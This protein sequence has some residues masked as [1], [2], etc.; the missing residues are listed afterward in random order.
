MSN[1]SGTVNN[2]TDAESEEY[3]PGAK[4]RRYK[5]SNSRVRESSGR[6]I[7][8]IQR[9][10]FVVIAAALGF[11]LLELPWNE[12]LFTME[13]HYV[14]P[15]LLI[16]F[17]CCVICYFLGQRTRVSLAVFVGLC[18]LGGYANF[19][20]IAFKGQPIVPADLFALNT[21][22]AVS[23]G[24]TFFITPSLIMCLALFVLFCLAL[25]FLCPKSALSKS[26][27]A[28][29][30]LAA[31]LLIC[32]GG[33]QYD[34]IDVKQDCEV[35]VDV[36]DVRGSY[37]T[38]GSALCFVSRMQ[39]LT[40]KQPQGYSPLAVQ[41]LVEPY[42]DQSTWGDTQ[43]HQDVDFQAASNFSDPSNDF[44]RPNI[45]V[46]MNETF[47]D[48]SRYPGLEDAQR[49]TEGY[50]HLAESSLASGNVYVSALGGGT[51]NS[52]FEFLTA[53]TMGLMGGGVYPYVLY[54]LEEVDNVVAYFNDLGYATSAIHPA[55]AANWRRDRIYAQLG[56]NRFDDI[57]AFEN[58]E[59][60]RDLTTDKA[61]YEHLLTILQDCDDPQ[62]IFDVT[63]QNHGGYDTGLVP[64]ED[65]VHLESSVIDNPEVDEFLA[66][67]ERS[68]KDL[69]WLTDA[70]NAYRE[71]T[72]VV[73]FGDH[74]PG[75]ADELFEAAYGKPVDGS[76]L[77]EVQQRYQTPYLIWANDATYEVYGDRIQ[78]LPPA[79]DMS[80]NY[81][82]SLL[83]TVLDLPQ[84]ARSRY[85]M[86]IHN[87]L[88]AVNL[89][90]YC[91]SDGLWHW[92][93]EAIESDA[94]KR[95]EA[96]LES[97]ELVQYDN[98]FA[99]DPVLHEL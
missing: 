39:E 51:C 68:D 15:N 52:E 5:G 93:G 29:N 32:L 84:T 2:S 23:G 53:S 67:I 3:V 70:L 41:A 96:A 78:A 11:L 90:G 82:S 38:Q 13:W 55:E 36:W 4:L 43:A 61:T 31:L 37:A 44:V 17:L 27:I 54:D 85:L 79:Q 87:D 28:P 6:I 89:N 74:Q 56:F 69:T 33:A 7:P 58:A 64:A 18:L 98:L 24:Y 10:I 94:Q 75:F 83:I 86:D 60:F 65:A 20:V 92:F 22:L 71:P 88:S 66:A 1:L 62:F 35:V 42:I 47:S 59:T 91:D 34:A 81:L 50:R 48:I 63:I 80:L 95:A 76:P 73:F 77:D 97:Y 19:F 99:S 40:P 30:C 21:A 26:D 8:V 49:F 25:Y 72:I 12:S 45:V 14:K 16:V 46:V 9:G 57:T